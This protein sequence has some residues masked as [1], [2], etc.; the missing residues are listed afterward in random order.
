MK[1]EIRVGICDRDIEWQR[2]VTEILSEYGRERN[3]LL[4]VFQFRNENMLLSY[5]GLTLDILFM[6]VTFENISGIELACEINKRWPECQILYLT[7]H[8]QYIFDVYRS[9]HLNYILK[10]QFE[11]KIYEIMDDAKNRIKQI[12]NKITVSI[13]GSNKILLSLEEIVYFE[14]EERITRVISLEG[15]HIIDEKISVLEEKLPVVDFV[16]C[17][18]SYIVYLPAVVK[19]TNKVFEMCDGSEVLISRG[20]REHTRRAFE[21]WAGVNMNNV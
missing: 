4:K 15:E 17:H 11:D 7:N 1:V 16:R 10:N 3:I 5:R 20:Y 13:H 12:F 18:H 2:K 6:D 19:Y 8:L 9:E 21:R 14:R